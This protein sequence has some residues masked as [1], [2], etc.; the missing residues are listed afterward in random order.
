MTSITWLPVW[1]V[2]GIR[3]VRYLYIVAETKSLTG[4]KGRRGT[5]VKGTETY[6]RQS[7]ALVLLALV[8]AIAVIRGQAIGRKANA[9]VGRFVTGID[10][11]RRR[12]CRVSIAVSADRKTG[13]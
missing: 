3:G 8:A 5:E 10:H 1:V 6:V 9:E 13:V 4:H 12:P 11:P 2:I 7:A